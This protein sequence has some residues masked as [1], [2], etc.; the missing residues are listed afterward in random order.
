M[1][2]PN[3]SVSDVDSEHRFTLWT[4]ARRVNTI[5]RISVMESR[6]VVTGEVTR[7][8]PDATTEAE[9]IV[10][11]YVRLVNERDFSTL[12]AVVAESFTFTSPTAGTVQ[13]REAFE[14]YLR[15]IVD[16]FSDFHLSV[17][18]TLADEGL[19]MM[20]GRVSGTHDG[21]FDGIEPTHREVDFPE[22]G[23]FAVEDGRLQEE[24]A[25][26]DHSAVLRQL[27]LGDE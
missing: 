25:Y 22:M 14:A 5:P 7:P 20:E 3:T 16:G 27:G 12:P 18:R 11:E 24:R 2:A 19:V 1:A 26:Y 4:C 13:G 21:E 8:M 15:T 9:R 17:N 10:T 23:V 6:H